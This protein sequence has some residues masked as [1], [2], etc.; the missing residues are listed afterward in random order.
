MMHLQ[1]YFNHVSKKEYSNQKHVSRTNIYIDIDLINLSSFKELAHLKKLFIYCQE[2]KKE[3]S[4]LWL[5]YNRTPDMM[6]AI[7]PIQTPKN[8]ISTIIS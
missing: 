5:N 4:L 8:I 1:E 6:L 2:N 3:T 7:G